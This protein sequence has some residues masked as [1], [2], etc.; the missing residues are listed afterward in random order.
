MA[1][2]AN[3]KGSQAAMDDTFTLTNMSPQV[4]R[5]GDV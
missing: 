5:G 4:G 3:H 2:A 1:P